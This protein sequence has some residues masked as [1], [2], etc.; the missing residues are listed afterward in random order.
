MNLQRCL[1]LVVGSVLGMVN[2]M[3]A[4]DTP[5]RYDFEEASLSSTYRADSSSQISLSTRHYKSGQQSLMWS[6]QNG[7]RLLFTDPEPGRDKRLTGFRAWVYNEQ[8]FENGVLTFSFGTAS[9]L[10]ANNPR[11]QFQFGLNFTGWRA[12]WVD[13]R[14]DAGNASYQGRK[15]GRATAFEISAPNNVSSGSVY[16]DLMEMVREVKH[17]AA[18]PQIPFVSGGID[19]ARGGRNREYRWSLN[20][21]PGPVLGEI[22]EEER[23]AFQTIAERYEAWVLGD[24]VMEDMREPVRIRLDALA[25][26]IR[27]GHR[28]LKK[29][30]I[31]REGDV[32]LG[33]PLFASRS[34]HRPGFESVFAEVL[35]RLVLDYRLNGDSELRD[36]LLD[37]FD[38]LHDQGWTADSGLGTLVH[39]FMRIAGYAH[40]V[41]LMREDLRATGR[42]EREGLTLEWHSMFGE[43]YEE[44]WDPGTNA[45]FLRTVAMYRLLRVLMMEDT[46]EKVAMMRCYLAWLNNALSIA[47]GWLDTIKPDYSGFHHRGI[48]ANA[49]APNAFHVASILVYLLRDTPFAVAD[50]KRDNVKQALLMTRVMANT[51]DISTALNG[52]YPFRTQLAIKLIP[53]YMY[54]AM[55]YTPV[56]AELSGAFMRI[57]NPKS[58]LQI[59][60]LFQKVS[61]SIMYLDTPGAV[62]MM[63]DFAKAGHTPEAAPSGHWTLPYGALSIHRRADW[64]VSLKGWSK[65]VW[66]YESSGSGH[67]QLGRYLSYGSMLI[68]ASGDPV[69]REASGIVPE[70]WDWSMW[71]GTT[72]IRLSHAELNKKQRDRNFSDETFVGGVNTEGQN[73]VFALKLHDTQH[74]PSFRAV[75][76]VFCF[77]DVL[78]CLGSGIENDDGGH[79]TVTTLFQASVSEDRPTGVNGESVRA[80]P[81][82][83]VGTAGQTAWVM[84]SRGNGYVIPDGG[85]L[86]MQRQVQTPGDFGKG[87]GGGTGIFELAYL[88]HGSAPQDASYHY[89]VLVQRSPDRVRAFANMPEYDVWQQDRYAHIVHHQGLKTTGYALFDIATRPV[90]GPVLAVSLPSLVMAREVDDG[91]LVS[92][93]DPD[94]GWN[95]TI[96]NPHRQNREL[97]TNQLSMSRIV[98][99]TLRGKWSLDGVYDLVMAT[100]QSEQTVVEFTCQDGKAVEVK[101]IR[102]INE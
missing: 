95:R 83:F 89:A 52:R 74:N 47:P 25:N 1:V 41:F 51:Y 81:Y 57:W 23:Q 22:T 19:N 91:L 93:A 98:N 34:P 73:G 39:E 7:G 58:Q 54:M 31:R 42:L 40:A 75:K 69:S 27:N 49:Y 24:N 60:D 97:I 17:A 65:Y 20:T 56:D 63:V 85:D 90:D 50:D 2:A 46:P 9:E 53:A 32:I 92:V 64:M 10:S 45:D 66:D 96:Q 26:S 15:N 12:M 100:V 29:F 16:L 70:G 61:A 11:Y 101:L 36:D 44:N 67:N 5:W 80:I 68:Y 33:K 21:L 76:T 86:H 18:D 35:L 72:V 14:E 71:P 55:S 84:D 59:N 62:Q 43:V 82:E 13:L 94:F 38:Y 37:L 78:V 79:A 28:N 3:M 88:D 8:A 77:G 87:G 99:V 4:Q 30:Q 48:Y 102:V 6:W